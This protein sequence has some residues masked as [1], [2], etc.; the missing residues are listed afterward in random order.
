MGKAHSV[1]LRSRVVEAVAEGISRRQ[2]GERFKVSASS[3]IRWAELKDETGDVRPR[4]RGHRK[5]PL[6]AYAAWLLELL[7]REPDLTL[8]AIAARLGEEQKVETSETSIRRFFKRH[9]ITFKKKPARGRARPAGRRAGP[10]ALAGRTGR[11]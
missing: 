1:D 5:S 11:P 7:A 9:A 2:A 10:R 4:P 6:D 8:E 3:A